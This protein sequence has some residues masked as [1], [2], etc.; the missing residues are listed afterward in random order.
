MIDAPTAYK[1]PELPTD[2]EL[3]P[4]YQPSPPPTPFEALCLFIHQ[5]HRA[6]TVTMFVLCISLLLWGGMNGINVRPANMT[7]TSG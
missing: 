7:G 2:D 6:W 5:H 3:A 4:T 1:R